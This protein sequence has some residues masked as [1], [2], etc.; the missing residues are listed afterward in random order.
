MYVKSCHEQIDGF[1]KLHWTF[2]TPIPMGSRFM[3]VYHYA[4]AQVMATT[5]PTVIS[6]T[7]ILFA[8]NKVMAY[9][10]GGSL[11]IKRIYL[12][13]SLVKEQT[14]VYQPIKTHPVNML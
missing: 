10:S 2:T 3:R 1:G 4:Y 9:Q 12:Y 5:I 8:H 13:Y 11:Y 7:L 14:T 6:G